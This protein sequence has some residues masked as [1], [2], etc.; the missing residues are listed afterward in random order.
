MEGKSSKEDLELTYKLIKARARSKN[1]KVRKRDF[2]RE[3][4]TRNG[5]G[6]KKLYRRS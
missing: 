6:I 3:I 4:T 5:N 1:T 2:D